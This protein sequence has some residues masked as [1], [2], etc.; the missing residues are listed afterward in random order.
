[1]TPVPFQAPPAKLLKFH[2]VSST[3]GFVP[4]LTITLVLRIYTHD[5]VLVHDHLHDTATQLLWCSDPPIFEYSHRVVSWLQLLFFRSFPPLSLFPFFFFLSRLFH[6][7]AWADFL[8]EQNLDEAKLLKSYQI[9]PRVASAPTFRKGIYAGGGE[10]G[11]I[12]ALTLLENYLVGRL[13]AP[14]FATTTVKA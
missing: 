13:A 2:E 5:A 12:Q 10:L 1:M 4:E 9:I 14:T 3:Q 6:S 7:E 8:K 11:A